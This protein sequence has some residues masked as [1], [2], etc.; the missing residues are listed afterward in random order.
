VRVRTASKKA[1]I[2][3]KGTRISAT[4]LEF[5]YEIPF[6]DAEL[7]LDSLCEKPII[8]KIRYIIKHSGFKWEVDEFLGDNKGLIVAEVELKSEKQK[9]VLPPWIGKEVTE[10]SRYANSSLVRNPYKSWATKN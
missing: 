2:T 3:I 7:M 9:I 6:E 4:R 5:E 8:E 1:F 10:D